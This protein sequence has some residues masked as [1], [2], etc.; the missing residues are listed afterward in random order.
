MSVGMVESIVLG[1]VASL[2]T[3]FG[4]WLA[5]TILAGWSWLETKGVW[6]I[7]SLGATFAPM[8]THLVNVT[9]SGMDA[10]AGAIE[11]AGPLGPWIGL[12]IALLAIGLVVQTGKGTLELIDPR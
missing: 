1:L 12:G 10:F 6:L 4:N 5:N 3:D 8:G 9:R 7:D 11:S 2:F